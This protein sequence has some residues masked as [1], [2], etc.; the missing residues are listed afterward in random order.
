MKDIYKLDKE[1]TAYNFKIYNKTQIIDTTI[2]QNGNTGD[3]VAY[4][5]G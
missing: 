4:K 3:Y 1:N 2:N 5:N